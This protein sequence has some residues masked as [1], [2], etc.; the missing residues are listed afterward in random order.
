MMED[1][2]GWREYGGGMWR[3]E[4]GRENDGGRRGVERVQRENDGGWRGWRV[5]RGVVE[6]EQSE[7]EEDGERSVEDRAGEGWRKKLMEREEV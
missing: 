5:R 3:T 2:E 7:G 6:G 1:G 4:Q